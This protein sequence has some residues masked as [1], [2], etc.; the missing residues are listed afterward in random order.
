MDGIRNNPQMKRTAKDSVFCDLFAQREYLLELY[1][2]LHPED[3]RT[4]ADDLEI[5]TLERVVTDGQ[6]NDVGFLAG[7]RLLMLVEA[8]S[9]WSENI[10]TRMFLY[11]AETYRRYIFKQNQYLHRAELV[12]LPAPELYVIYTGPRNV[13]D[14]VSFRTD[15]LGGANSALDLDVQVLRAGAPG[16]VGQYVEFTHIVDAVRI[17]KSFSLDR[18]AG[19][20]VRRCIERGILV[21]YMEERRKEVEGIMFTLFDQERETQLYQEE[22]KRIAQEEGW[23]EGHDAGFK[24]GRDEGIEQ[25]IEQGIKQGIEQGIEQGIAVSVSRLMDSQGMTI[26]QAMDALA[27]SDADRDRIS[28]VVKGA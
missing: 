28:A 25:G 9:T 27:V 20:V 13:P 3:M 12:K 14:A 15:V 19:E 26:A 1:Q 21:S 18:K 7:N 16:V 10:V 8:Q 6:Y 2:V 17:D 5:V 23:K 11:L 4:T 22:L 24:S